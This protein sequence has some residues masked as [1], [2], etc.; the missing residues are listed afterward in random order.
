MM[1]VLALLTGFGFAVIGGI[2]FI[3]YMNLFTVGFSLLKYLA[4]MVLRPESYLFL[5]GVA[6]IWSALYYPEKSG[7]EE[8]KNV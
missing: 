5:A 4:F 1:R 6:L 3:A 2:T 7:D 8:N